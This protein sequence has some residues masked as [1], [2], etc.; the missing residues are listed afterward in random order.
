LSTDNTVAEHIFKT[1]VY[2]LL[3]FVTGFPNLSISCIGNWAEARIRRS[4]RRRTV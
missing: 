4:L 2:K 1:Y 3:S